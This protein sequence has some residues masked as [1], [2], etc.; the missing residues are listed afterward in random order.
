MSKSVILEM[1]A[2]HISISYPKS[3]PDSTELQKSY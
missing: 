3:K 2:G 1:D